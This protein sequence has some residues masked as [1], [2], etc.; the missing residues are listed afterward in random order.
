MNKIVHGII[1]GNTIE[2]N[3]NPGISDGQE[4]RVILSVAKKSCPWGEGLKN[5][6]G[7]LADS[8]TDQ[9]DK[10]LEEIY[11]ERKKKLHREIPE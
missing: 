11:Q 7:A 5:S 2:L 10:I 3:E 1:H 6:A 8:W 9:D 4:V